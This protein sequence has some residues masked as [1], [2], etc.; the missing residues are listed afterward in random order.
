MYLN[1]SQPAATAFL[2]GHRVSSVLAISSYHNN[3]FVNYYYYFN[4]LQL[5]L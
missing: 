4:T 5:Y 2:K 3:A 1:L